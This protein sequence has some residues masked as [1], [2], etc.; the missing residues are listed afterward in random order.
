MASS[1]TA[2]GITWNW[3]TSANATSYQFSTDNTT[4]TDKGNITSFNETGLVCG[5]S[6]IRYVKACSAGECSTAT[7]L[8]SAS[9][10][11]C[12]RVYATWNPGDKNSGIVLSNGNLTATCPSGAN[13]VRA[14]I[15][16]NSGKW[17]W[18][19]TQNTTSIEPGIANNS[20]SLDYYLGG[21]ANGWMYYNLGQ[22]YTN[23]IATAYGASYNS[24]DVL[25]VALDMDN[26]TVSFLKNNIF[27][28][29]AYT[30]LT[31]AIY[32][33]T[34]SDGGG[35]VA[36]TANFGASPLTY[37]PP[38]GTFW[39]PKDVGIGISTS[40][41]NLTTTDTTTLSLVR[42]NTSKSSGKWYWEVTI[43]TAGLCPGVAKS[44]ATSWN[45]KGADS[46]GWYG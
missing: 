36:A 32:P 18:E 31:G 4:F 37:A 46:W 45:G 16:K 44:T 29:I 43:N 11:A 1:I 27:Q 34:G 6:Y 5:T 26:G 42:T 10:N 41:N 35:G 17:Y 40:N 19:Y 8:A 39:N 7:M 21:T 13:T 12:P 20:A 30:G 28:G 23:Y 14:T 15:G 2:T 38:N 9:T 22:K 3:Q 24:T 25:G 33:A